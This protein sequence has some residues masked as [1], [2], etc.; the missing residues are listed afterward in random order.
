MLC[1]LAEFGSTLNESVAEQL[2]TPLLVELVGEPREAR[3]NVSRQP[4]NSLWRS[5]RIVDERRLM[6]KRKSASPSMQTPLSQGPKQAGT[7]SATRRRKS[8]LDRNR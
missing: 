7:C 1:K 5:V 4:P 8:D 3:P 6:K 2:V